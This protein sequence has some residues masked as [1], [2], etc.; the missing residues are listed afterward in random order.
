MASLIKSLNERP[1]AA[2]GT[3]AVAAEDSP[4]AAGTLGEA[5]AVAAAG[6]GVLPAVTFSIVF[7]PFDDGV[8]GA[9]MG[10]RV[11]QPVVAKAAANKANKEQNN[12]VGD[13]NKLLKRVTSND[14]DT[15]QVV[16]IQTAPSIVIKLTNK[17][18][19]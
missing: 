12:G 10:D 14:G 3:D 7:G 13:I 8:V 2:L 11:E 4:E 19:A 15:T 18:T 5:T 17:T 6:A 16:G 1:G 9:A